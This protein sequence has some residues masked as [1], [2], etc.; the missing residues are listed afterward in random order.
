[1]LEIIGNGIMT[2]A[3]ALCLCVLFC[4]ER[5]DSLTG[6]LSTGFTLLFLAIL[7]TLA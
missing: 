4:Y 7:H 6:V 2:V 3:M 1:M 5:E